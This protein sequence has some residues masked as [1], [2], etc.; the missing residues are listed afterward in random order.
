MTIAAEIYRRWLGET[1]APD[2]D[3]DIREHLPELHRLAHGRRVLEL[4]LDRGVS[5]SALL[6]AVEAS[7]ERM[8]SVDVRPDCPAVKLFEGETAWEFVCGDSVNV[9]ADRLADY[10]PTM[11]FIDTDHSFERTM[12]ELFAWGDRTLRDGGIVALHDVDKPLYPG[13]REAVVE[14]ARVRGR[15]VEY[16]PGSFGLAI[17]R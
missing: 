16:R 12:S 2:A 3:S 8:I 13:V 11:L 17:I 4:G 7:G 15:R 10:R 14:Y 5:T 6:S 9:I 1:L